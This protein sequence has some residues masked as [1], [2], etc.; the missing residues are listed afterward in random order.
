MRMTFP[1]SRRS[2]RRRCACSTGR[3]MSMGARAERMLASRLVQLERKLD[4]PD[5]ETASKVWAEY[6]Q[7]LDLWLRV[8]GPVAAPPPITKAML[9]ERFNH[10]KQ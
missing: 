4:A 6:Y 9:A 8:R 1:N 2:R 5:E 10:A 3:M 7:A